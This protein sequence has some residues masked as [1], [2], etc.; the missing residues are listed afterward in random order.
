MSQRLL[1]LAVETNTPQPYPITDSI[2]VAPLTRTRTRDLNAAELERYLLCGLLNRVVATPLGPE[3]V[4]PPEPDLPE[5]PTAEQQEAYDEWAQTR[6]AHAAW[7]ASRDGAETRAA[8]LNAK[9]AEAETRYDKAFFGDAYAKVM[10]YFED[11][12][13]LWEKFVPDIRAEFLPPAPDNGVCPT[14]GHVD[15][16]QAGK[17]QASST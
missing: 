3:P 9:I 6:D 13:Q 14:C 10:E 11:K 5:E 15:E 12:P 2:V 4:V 7:V 17:A 8:E 16:E 1:D